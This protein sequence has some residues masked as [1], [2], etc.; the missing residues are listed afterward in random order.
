MIKFA[1]FR[2]YVKQALIHRWEFCIAS[3]VASGFAFVL[4][5]KKLGKRRNQHNERENDD[6]FFEDREQ[7]PELFIYDDESTAT[8]EFSI[9]GEIGD[10]YD[11]ERSFDDIPLEWSEIEPSE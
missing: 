10:G 3:L 6:D 4:F 11:S 5:R 2:L 8:I 1:T 7:A 9:G